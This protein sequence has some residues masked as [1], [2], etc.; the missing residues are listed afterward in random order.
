MLPFNPYLSYLNTYVFTEKSL[1]TSF[2][3]LVFV[4]FQL[5]WEPFK[6]VPMEQWLELMV[7]CHFCIYVSPCFHV[8]HC[9]VPVEEALNPFCYCTISPL[10]SE[11]L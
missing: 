6:F 1:N 10:H 9:F 3:S 2:D 11:H 4:L 7:C 8:V 5:C